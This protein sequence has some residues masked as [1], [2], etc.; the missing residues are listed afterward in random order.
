MKFGTVLVAGLSCVLL[1]ACAS[2]SG[3]NKKKEVVQEAPT[4]I[5]YSNLLDQKTRT[6]VEKQLLTVLPKENVERF[7][8]QVVEFNE[9]IPTDSLAQQGFETS[10]KLIPAYDVGQMT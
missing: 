3:A 10:K 6:E 5:Q 8:S 4:S 9:T 7:L 2:S 1:S